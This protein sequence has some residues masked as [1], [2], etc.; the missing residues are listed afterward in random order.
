ME[1]DIQSYSPTSA[2]GGRPVTRGGVQGCR[3][4]P[5]LLKGGCNDEFAPPPPSHIKEI[6]SHN[7][8]KSKAKCL[9][10]AQHSQRYQT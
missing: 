8:L 3:C 5:F 7:F 10:Y 1:E 6:V 2:V 4:T 9:G